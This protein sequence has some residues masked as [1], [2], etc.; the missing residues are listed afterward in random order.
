MT[1]DEGGNSPRDIAPEDVN[2]MIGK[3]FGDLRASLGAIRAETEPIQDTEVSETVSASISKN[4]AAIKGILDAA[5]AKIAKLTQP[6]FGWLP[7]W[8]RDGY[9]PINPTTNK[10]FK[11]FN[12][13]ALAAEA[14]AQGFTDPRWLTRDQA[15]ASGGS[16][17]NDQ[18]P[19]MVA[20]P[21]LVEYVTESGKTIEVIDFVEREVFNA[22]QFDGMA[23]YTVPEKVKYTFNEAMQTI[24]DRY[25]QGEIARGR[26]GIPPLYGT[27]MGDDQSP[28][29][30]RI[31]GIE[32]IAM[33]L[34][35]QFKTDEA[36]LSALFHEMLHSTGTYTR[37][38]RA[39]TSDR[40]SKEYAREEI[41]VELATTALLE[42][43]GVETSGANST[44]IA[45][46]Q[47]SGGLT[48]E[49]LS[50]ASEDALTAIEYILGNDVLPTWDPSATKNF[51]TE[52]EARNNNA[53]SLSS[54]INSSTGQ[55]AIN[56]ID[57]VDA[58]SISVAQGVKPSIDAKTKV[59]EALVEKLKQLGGKAVP[60]RKGFKDGFEYTGG[61]GL[62]R[63]PSSKRLYSGFNSFFLKVAAQAEGYTDSRWLTYK[64]AQ[65]LGGQVRK[66]EKGMPILVPMKAFIDK[67]KS[68][69]P[70]VNSKGDP[71]GFSRI[72][73][74]TA[75]VFN[76]SQIDGLNLPDDIPS[77]NM[78]PVEAQEF[79]IERYKKSMEAK[80][81]AIPKIE[82]SYVGEYSD[83]NSS[84]NWRG[85]LD[86]AIT[87]PNMAQFEN[88]E[89]IFD[90]LMH[91]L[92]HS[93]GHQA[94]LDRS[95]LI[96]NYGNSDNQARA[97]EELIAEMGAAIL[98]EMFGVNYDVENTQAYMQSWASVL[99]NNNADILHN[100][101]SMAQKAV[102]YMLGMD[103]GD[104]SPLEGYNNY[105]GE[106]GKEGEE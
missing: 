39:L 102:D 72:F 25:K 94:R 62:P 8:A 16:L 69:A 45:E 74:R 43:M 85:G 38:G 106:Q 34:R 88:P 22:E 63:N 41:V 81:L 33:P 99:S 3:I 24:V 66:G 89:A 18:L 93:T 5:R 101:S 32:S 35:E 58:P 65:G 9:R 54:S 100:A 48:P 44:Y 86:D 90:T 10:D 82:Y 7:S 104:W 95:E 51:T 56:A 87:L 13:V 19:T 83:H 6:G 70:L 11:S 68:G 67:D 53:T 98:G 78:S 23:E 2:D 1:P 17:K 96:K 15:E 46:W 40:D 12:L 4:K 75:T 26:K 60:W 42:R 103:L 61:S 97:Q 52:A 49:D 77:T 20:V 36:Y 91:E 14:E 27:K 28:E 73:F 76:V 79:I 59:L 31:S 92:T 47:V 84:P 21:E 80:G 105:L 55:E 64:Q 29:F 30:T 50:R 37:T 57:A 71:T